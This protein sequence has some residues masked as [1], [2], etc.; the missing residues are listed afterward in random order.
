MRVVHCKREPS[1]KYIVVAASTAIR[2]RATV[3]SL[4]AAHPTITKVQ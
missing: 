4:F 1:T 2:A 3:I